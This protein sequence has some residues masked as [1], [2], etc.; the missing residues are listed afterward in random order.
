MIEGLFFQ[1]NPN[2]KLMFYLYI[3]FSKKL[4]KY[5]VGQTDNIFNR[6]FQHNSGYSKFTSKASDWEL[7]YSEEFDLRENAY[8]R[9]ME[10]KKKKSRKYIYIKYR[11]R[12]K[13]HQIIN[14]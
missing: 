1:T 8:K 6:L 7:K 11:S 2:R 10:I 5:Y 3:I 14:F 9:E 4:D 12:H 13:L